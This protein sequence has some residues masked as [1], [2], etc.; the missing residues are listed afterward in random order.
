MLVYPVPKYLTAAAIPF[1]ATGS[2]TATVK[3]FD[4]GTLAATTT[5]TITVAAGIVPLSGALLQPVTESNTS[6][7]LTTTALATFTDGGNGSLIND[8]SASI[9]WGDGTTGNPDITAGTITFSNG[10]YTITGGNHGYNT[11]GSDTITVTLS[12][13]GGEVVTPAFVTDTVTVNPSITLTANPLSIA[14][15]NAAASIE[16][17]TFSNADGNSLDTY[18]AQVT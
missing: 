8:Y 13:S 16:L 10:Q 6:S 14:Q 7:I 11:A 2:V 9:N 5:D 1:L 4:N 18:T 12:A 3:F 17:A 15:G